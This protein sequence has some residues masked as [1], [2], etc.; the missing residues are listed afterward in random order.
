MNQTSKL[1]R[2]EKLN[3]DRSKSFLKK[4][5]TRKKST[6]TVLIHF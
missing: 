1:S 5:N 3:T 2:K 6:S 4:L